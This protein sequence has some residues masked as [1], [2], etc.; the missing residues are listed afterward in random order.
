MR[1]IASTADRLYSGVLAELITNGTRSSPRGQGTR[2][3][4]GCHLTL[5]N[6]NANV[7]THPARKLNYAFMIAEWLYILS[8]ANYV[9]LIA[10]FNSQMQKFAEGEHLSGA[11]GPKILEQINYVREVLTADHDTRQAIITL[12]RER[13]RSSKDIPC[14]ISLQF[15]RRDDRLHMIVYMRSNDAWLGLPYDLF[16]FTQLQRQLA[17]ECGTGVGEYHHMVGSL[18]L[19]DRNVEAA[20]ELVTDETPLPPFVQEPFTSFPA[21]DAVSAFHYIIGD[22]GCPLADVPGYVHMDKLWRGYIEMLVWYFRRTVMM[23][24]PWSTLTSERHA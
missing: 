5:T 16:N 14:T 21:L 12:W 24:R 23:V 6:P 3:R 7:V 17:F 20:R 2:E 13:P 11:Y 18:H 9:G 22:K 8:G 15:I 4:I 1:L 19:Y 10:P